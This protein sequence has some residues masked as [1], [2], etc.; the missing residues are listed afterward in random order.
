M[1][2]AAKRRKATTLLFAQSCGYGIAAASWFSLRPLM[3]SDAI[4]MLKLA[5][6]LWLAILG[7]RLIVSNR[8]ETSQSGDS[9]SVLTTTALNPKAFIYCLAIVP[10]D[11]EP[12]MLGIFWTVLLVTTSATGSLWVLLGSRLSRGKQIADRVAGTALIVFALV[13]L[14]PLMALAAS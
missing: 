13:L 3:P 1:A 7:L 4:Q 12:R 2:G 9:L 14:R 8:I 6:A 10:I 5:A 11:A